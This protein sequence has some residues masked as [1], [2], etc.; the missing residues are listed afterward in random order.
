WPSPCGPHSHTLATTRP[1]LAHDH[2]FV[3][4]TNVSHTRPAVRG[5]TRPCGINRTVFRL[6][7]KF[8][9]CISGTHLVR[10]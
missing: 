5:T 10:L 4:H 9:F 3:D 6:L 7:P 8:D 2:T 1:C